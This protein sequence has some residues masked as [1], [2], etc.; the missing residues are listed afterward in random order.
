MTDF[1]CEVQIWFYIS[2][3]FIGKSAEILLLIS[4]DIKLLFIIIIEIHS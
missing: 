1:Y 2:F 4:F 3:R